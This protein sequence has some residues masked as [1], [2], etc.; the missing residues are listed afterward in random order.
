MAQHDRFRFHTLEELERKI[1]EPAGNHREDLSILGHRASGRKW[2]PT[3]W[4]PAHGSC[5]GQEWSAL[6]FD[7][8]RYQRFGFAERID[9]VRGPRH[10]TRPA[11]TPANLIH[12]EFSK[13]SRMVDATREAAGNPCGTIRFWLQLTHSGR[14][15]RP[16]DKPADHRPSQRFSIPATP[17]AG[18]SLIT[19]DELTAAR[20]LCPCRPPGQRGFDAVDIKSRQRYLISERWRRSPAKQPLWRTV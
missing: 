8:R 10:R 20:G 12:D 3:Y 4:V 2:F 15:S 16:V 1:E 5:D 6:R 7:L 13:I 11:P 17:A 18:L 14:H 9:L 19:D